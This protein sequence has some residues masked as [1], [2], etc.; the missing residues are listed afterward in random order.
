[1]DLLK[2][3]GKKYTIFDNLFYSY[4]FLKGYLSLKIIVSYY[5]QKL[6]NKR[7]LINIFG[8]LK[9]MYIF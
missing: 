6:I 2:E 3:Y 4:K 9:I 5:W 7:D 8:C 1:M